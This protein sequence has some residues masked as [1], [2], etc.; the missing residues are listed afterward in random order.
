MVPFESCFVSQTA[1]TFFISER[2]TVAHRYPS[3]YNLLMSLFIL[4]NQKSH[5]LS[6]SMALSNYA[7][8]VI[9]TTTICV[10]SVGSTVGLAFGAFKLW[11]MKKRATLYKEGERS[12]TYPQMV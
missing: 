8:F 11:Q 1:Q 5:S 9:A 12:Q 7:N 6:D 3:L 2:S 4:V 10:L